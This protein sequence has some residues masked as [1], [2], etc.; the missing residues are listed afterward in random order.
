[1]P[2]PAK[3]RSRCAACD[4]SIEVGQDIEAKRGEKPRHADCNRS[5]IDEAAT[6]RTLAYAKSMTDWLQAN[7]EPTVSSFVVRHGA[8]VL[9]LTGCLTEEER[10]YASKDHLERAQRW[11]ARKPAL[12]T[13]FEAE[14]M[15]WE[16]MRAAAE[17]NFMQGANHDPPRR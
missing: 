6:Q 1:M 15:A 3:Y 17:E 13:K 11:L 9:D 2:F 16:K 10:R 5:A 14:R 4:R 12:L 8:P 7:P